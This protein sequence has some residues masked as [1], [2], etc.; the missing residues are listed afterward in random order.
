MLLVFNFSFNA[1]FFHQNK[2]T[3]K[4]ACGAPALLLFKNFRCSLGKQFEHFSH[5]FAQS[6]KFYRKRDSSTDRSY[7]RRSSVRKVIFRNFEKFIGKHMCQSLFLI[8]LQTSACNFIKKETLAQVFSCVFCEI[9]NTSGDCFFCIDNFQ[10][11][12]RWKFKK[13]W[14]RTQKT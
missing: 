3:T 8:T 11:F 1:M 12:L 4:T 10:W 5:I 2:L 14:C 7:H 9:S 13:F 6:L